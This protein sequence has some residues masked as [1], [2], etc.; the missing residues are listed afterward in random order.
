M[1]RA[2]NRRRGFGANC[3]RPSS[4]GCERAT[5]KVAPTAHGS[6]VGARLALAPNL[7]QRERITLGTYSVKGPKKGHRLPIM[8]LSQPA[9]QST[10]CPYP[11]KIAACKLSSFV[12]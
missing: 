3:G 12:I 6:V 9:K 4:H 5:V 7:A 10:M 2:V 11:V 1:P 8:D